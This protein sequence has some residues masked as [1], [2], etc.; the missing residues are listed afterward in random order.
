MFIYMNNI[1][2]QKKLIIIR[3]LLNG[4]SYLRELCEKLKLPLTTI[5]AEITP[6][7]KNDMLLTHFK[8]NKKYFKLNYD[9]PLTREAVKLTII[10]KI[11]PLKSFQKMTQEKGLIKVYLYGSASNGTFDKNSDIDLAIIVEEEKQKTIIEKYRRQIEKEIG[12]EMDLVIVTR[13]EFDSLVDEK[14]QILINIQQGTLLYG[15]IFE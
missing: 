4:E 1:F 7:Q 2:N 11:I 12:L 3:E 5:H 14:R 9:S 15:K 10:Q 6:L 13:K 8:K